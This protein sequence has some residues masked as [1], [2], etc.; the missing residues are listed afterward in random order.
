MEIARG[1]AEALDCDDPLAH[2]RDEFVIDDEALIYLDG[3][4]LGMLPRATPDSRCSS[5]LADSWAG[6]VP[7]GLRLPHTNASN[8]LASARR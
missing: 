1:Y 5:R 4:S 7:V 8:G 6:P 3:N 2:Y